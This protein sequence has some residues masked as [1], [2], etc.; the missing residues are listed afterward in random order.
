MKSLHF[1]KVSTYQQKNYVENFVQ[2]L[3]DGGLAGGKQGATLVVSTVMI[4][5]FGVMT[6]PAIS[7]AIRDHRTDGGI[8]ISAGRRLGGKQG[9]FGIKLCLSNGGPADDIV[10]SRIYQLTKTIKEYHTC[11]KL[12]VKLNRVGEQVVRVGA[13]DIMRII[14]FD[15]VK[16]YGK[17]MQSL[18]DF[19]QMRALFSGSITGN[20]VRLMIDG[21]NGGNFERL[22][23]FSVDHKRFNPESDFGGL[24]SDPSIKNA[25]DFLIEFNQGNYEIG[26][27]FS[28]DGTR[29]LII[30]Q[31]GLPVAVSTSLA[32]VAES[33]QWLPFFKKSKDVKGFGRSLC[34]SRAVDRVAAALGIPCYEVSDNQIYFN[35]LM[36]EGKITIFGDELN[37]VSFCHVR[38]YDGIWLLL[39]WL[40]IYMHKK[41]AVT[42]S[43]LQFWETY[44]RHVFCK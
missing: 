38:E 40:S 22:G 17:C 12:E 6:T 29:A 39:A 4:G 1:A 21:R 7:L 11:T 44:G 28:C 20:P 19:W 18:F 33:L 13:K 43:I 24:P 35:R 41:L 2:C 9:L 27:V 5:Q 26:A 31:D 25:N 10:N 16:E 23:V 42:N 37:G 30:A 15:S 14:V 3:L 34:T 36:D 8:V 32:V